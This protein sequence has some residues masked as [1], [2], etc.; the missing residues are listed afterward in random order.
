MLS[1]EPAYILIDDRLATWT[2]S[3]GIARPT[4]CAVHPEDE[5]SA[6]TVYWAALL[7]KAIAKWLSFVD[8]D[9][10]IGCSAFVMRAICGAERT[11]EARRSHQREL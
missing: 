5:S 3:Y 6:V 2:D 11:G 8:L 7:D 9:G 4:H 1:E 10:G